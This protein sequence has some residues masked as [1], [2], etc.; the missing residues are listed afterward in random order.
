MMYHEEVSKA[1]QECKAVAAHNS[2]IAQCQWTRSG[3][4]LSDLA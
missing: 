2:H 3:V 4:Q 1:V